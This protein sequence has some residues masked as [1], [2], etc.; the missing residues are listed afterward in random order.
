MTGRAQVSVARIEGTGGM[1]WESYGGGV[2]STRKERGLSLSLLADLALTT[3]EL[4]QEVES[5]GC[6]PGL[7]VA[8]DLDRA[9][10]AGGELWNAWASAHLAALFRSERPPTLT[11]ALAEAFQV[12]AYAPLVLPDPYLTDSYAAALHRLEAPMNL[13]LSTDA[14]PQALGRFHPTA[15]TT[16]HC[17]VV[18]ETALT[19]YLAPAEIL[20]AQLLHLHH[21]AQQDHVTVHLIPATTGPHP[22]LRGAFWTLCYSP[23]RTI[24]YTPHPC[25]TGHFHRESATVKAH[26]DLYSTL[27]GVALPAEDS[28]HRIAE[29][30]ARLTPSPCQALSDH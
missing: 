30:A 25:G 5:G 29:L 8:R 14:R 27:Q 9:L 13:P 6:D 17:L 19:R 28:L 16:S 15:A 23:A 3:P 10:N 22:G 12:R 21:L 26:T 18:D 7:R 11:G 4:L 2:W 20:R 24:V 1:D